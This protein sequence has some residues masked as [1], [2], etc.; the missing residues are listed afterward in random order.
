MTV[1]HI[2]SR[3]CNNICRLACEVSGI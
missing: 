3:T 2:S 1:S